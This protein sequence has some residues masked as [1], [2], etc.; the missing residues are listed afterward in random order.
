MVWKT[1]KSFLREVVCEGEP[2]NLGVTEVWAIQE[3]ESAWSSRWVQHLGNN[4]QAVVAG[5]WQGV[6]ERPVLSA[7]SILA[8]I[9]RES[10]LTRSVMK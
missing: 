6:D 2:H 4:K 9:R 1:G 8:L 5:A 7:E 3:L 10:V